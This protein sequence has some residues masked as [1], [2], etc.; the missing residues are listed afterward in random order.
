[1]IH[2][3]K[4]Q[5]I[6]ISYYQGNV[7]FEKVKQSGIQFLILREGYRQ[8]LD[9][10]FQDYVKKARA[11]GIPILGVYHFSYALNTA[12]A[13]KEAKF[14][15]KQMKKAGL[16]K[17]VIIFYDFEYDTIK[18]AAVSGVKLGAEQC[19]AHTKAFCE[20][21][22]KKGYKAGVYANIDY[23]KTMYDHDLLSNYIFWLADYSGSPD[24]PC[25]FQQYSSKGSV[26]GISG[27]V[28]MDYCY[29]KGMIPLTKPTTKPKYSRQAVV[30]LAKSWV[31][32]NEKDGSYKA[33]IDI[34][35][36][37]SG[38]FPRGTKMDYSWAWCAAT[39]S[40]LAIKLDY[41]E[42]MPIEIS[43][44]YL[45]EAAKK[46]SCWVE[47]DNYVPSPGDAI[48]YDWEDSGSGDNQGTPDHVGIVEYVSGGYITVIEG[49][50]DDAVKRRTI[51]VNGRYIRGFI[52]PKY[53]SQAVSGPVQEPNKSIDQIAHEVITGIWGD[54]E[55]RKTALA[56]AG[57]DYNA[58]QSRVNEILNG[59]TTKPTTS[60]TKQVTAT[61]K[62]QSFRSSL[63][64]TYRV[65]ANSGLYLRNDA[66]TNKKALCLL[67]NG[68]K[69]QNY[70]YY[71]TYNGVK[72]LYI[73][74]TL[75]GIQYTG[76]SSKE[77]LNK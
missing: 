47:A 37:Y 32:K 40:A 18:K 59:S 60:T 61:A 58:V 62:A 34:Y 13:E 22:T 74:V 45:I 33:I 26:S 71:T 68:T 72:W 63:A 70:G 27:N 17:D 2:V 41:T 21:V 46:M 66:G 69:V 51:S 55:T 44:Y 1:M 49:N 16:G 5:G 75:N 10:R 77:Y 54:G 3:A 56:K 52:V 64:G 67:P 14:C 36:S 53:D 19:N 11:A 65:T 35:N 15:I 7:D 38:P 28:D 50:K 6:D 29:L 25:A 43:C 73:Q 20:Y 12:E 42:I 31:N 24:Y 76:F 9:S 30:D 57:Y 39:W 4:Y 23:Y 48:L 8:T